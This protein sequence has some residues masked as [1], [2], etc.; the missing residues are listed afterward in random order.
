M[1]KV[2]VS[3]EAADVVCHHHLQK[4]KKA[5]AL[6]LITS[7]LILASDLTWSVVR[8]SYN[9]MTTSAVLHKST[10]PIYYRHNQS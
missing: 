6:T 1:L 2:K 5:K 9:I 4:I 8:V 3:Y 7:T 10:G